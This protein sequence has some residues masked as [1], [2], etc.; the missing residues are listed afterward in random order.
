MFKTWKIYMLALI[1]FLVGTSEYI[2]A[3]IL[4]KISAS[5]DISL[6][7]AGQLITVFSLV[8]GL[9]TPFL[10]AWTARWERRKLLIYSLGLFVVANVLAFILP[11]FAAFIGARILMALGAGVVVVTALTVAAKIAP[12]GKQAS[13]IATVIMGFTA[14]LIVGVPL[15]RLVAAA[16]DWKTVFAGIGALGL[17]AMFVLSVTI[18]KTEGDAPVPLREQI[19]LLKQP[20]ILLA[21]S[22]SFF[23][24]GGYSIAYTYISPY[25][26]TIT[27]MNEKMLSAA[28]LAFGIASLAGSKIGGYSAD[29]WGVYRT[30][31]S[32]M[33]LHVITLLL[34][35]LAAHSPVV[36]FAVLILWSFAAWS[37]GPTQQYNLVTMAPESSGIMLSLNNSVMQLSMAAGAGIGGIIVGSVSLNAVTWIG[38]VGVAAAIAINF[39]SFKLSVGERRKAENIRHA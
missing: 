33:T 16:Y 10:I 32:G 20:R 31:M 18:P 4:D 11:G 13:A 2:I 25:L 3:G 9:G 34:L 19:A 23:W 14:S 39:V 5:L 38:A 22:V 8:Y 7:A 6:V 30:L 1:S 15:G 26:L 35:T 27:G 28:L 24:L 29:K 12:S 21:L 36:V 17:L 37:S